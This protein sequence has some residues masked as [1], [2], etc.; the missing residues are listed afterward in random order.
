[1]LAYWRLTLICWLIYLAVT[2]NFELA[3]L[4]VGLLIGWVIAAILKPASQSLSLRR[5][6]AA[7]FN[8][9]KYTAWLAVDIIRNGIR[10]ARIVLDP[11]LPIRPGIIA[12]PAG[13]KSELG[14]AL[15]AHAITVT[16]GEQVVEIGDDGVMYVHCLDVV[17]S[18]AGAEEAQRKRRAMLQR[19]FE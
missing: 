2:A 16:P 13:M 14:V 15:S 10:V 3:N 19:I 12:I 18:A 5:L 7:L 8:L 6:P 4:V 17:T 11:K 9:A 1:M